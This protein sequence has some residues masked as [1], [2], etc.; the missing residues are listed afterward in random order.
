VKKKDLKVLEDLLYRKSTVYELTKMATLTDRGL[1]SMVASTSEHLEKLA[2]GGGLV[3][4][5]KG[6]RCRAASIRLVV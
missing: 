3:D 1:T 6:H 5:V 2:R 4:T